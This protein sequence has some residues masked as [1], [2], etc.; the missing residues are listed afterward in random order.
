MTGAV[1]N[2]VPLR[3]AWSHEETPEVPSCSATTPATVV[4]TKNVAGKE[5]P[6]PDPDHVLVEDVGPGA[7]WSADEPV[8]AGALRGRA[9]GPEPRRHEKPVVGVQGREEQP[10]REKERHSRKWKQDVRL[11][12]C[13][14]QLFE[15]PRVQQGAEH[16]AQTE[17]EHACQEL[18]DVD[19]GLDLSPQRLFG[20]RV[21][22]LNRPFDRLDR[23][24]ARPQRS[25]PHRPPRPATHNVRCAAPY[26]RASRVFAHATQRAGLIFLRAGWGLLFLS[27]FEARPL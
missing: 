4:S 1:S 9:L 17:D 2:S 14:V 26:P 13:G 6:L 18:R 27:T 7:R 22:D 8:R 24:I 10:D 15:L 25:S 23:R 21:G 12:T 11:G 3:F 5:E 20:V 19:L 16:D